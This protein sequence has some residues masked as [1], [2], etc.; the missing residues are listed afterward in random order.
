MSEDNPTVFIVIHLSWRD[1]LRVLFGRLQHVDVDLD[2]AIPAHVRASS[3]V[4]VEHF[5]FPWQ[6]PGG[7]ATINPERTTP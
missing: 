6:H 2:M 7:Y 1:R 3:R 4:W 5:Q